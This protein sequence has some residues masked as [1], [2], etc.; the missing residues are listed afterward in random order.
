MSY[1]LFHQ[2]LE[3]LEKSLSDHLTH[4][5]KSMADA[6]NKIDALD[7][8]VAKL[9]KPVK[10]D[11]DYDESPSHVEY[12][13]ECDH[14]WVNCFDGDALLGEVCLDCGHIRRTK[15]VENDPIIDLRNMIIDIQNSKRGRKPDIIH[16]VRTH[17]E[18]VWQSI[19]A[20]SKEKLK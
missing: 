9:E 6:Q 4:Y 3:A 2:R 13:R 18:Q 15:P 7:K 14:K 12:P 5:T 11:P 19:E 1:E 20:Y 16:I 17:A 10:F 8:R